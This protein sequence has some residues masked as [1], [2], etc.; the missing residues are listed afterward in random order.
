MA[1]LKLTLKY[2]IRR[3]PGAPQRLSTNGVSEPGEK[4]LLYTRYTPGVP[5]RD[6]NQT[7]EFWNQARR[8]SPFEPSSQ[9]QTSSQM[10]PRYFTVVLK[11]NLKTRDRLTQPVLE[12]DAARDCG[13]QSISDSD[14]SQYGDHKT[15]KGVL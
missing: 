1:V 8:N 6:N 9:T 2:E 5:E 7:I 12:Q 13:V 4:K 11:Q 14:S 15:L 10:I 3:Q